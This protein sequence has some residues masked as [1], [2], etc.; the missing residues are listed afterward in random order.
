MITLKSMPLDKVIQ[1]RERELWGL[2]HIK[3]V[4]RLSGVK[5]PMGNIAKGDMYPRDF[6]FGSLL[7]RCQAYE[8]NFN[9]LTP[10]YEVLEVH[11][12]GEIFRSY[13]E[14]YME[15]NFDMEYTLKGVK[16]NAF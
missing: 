15:P 14:C 5:K 6:K 10:I 13:F 2:E 1:T 12:T 16:K 4:R 9:Y 11:T 7:R 3:Q 8:K